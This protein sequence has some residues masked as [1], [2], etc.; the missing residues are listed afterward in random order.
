MSETNANRAERGRRLVKRYRDAGVG[1]RA[2]YAI[3]DTPEEVR[4][5][6]SLYYGRA[7]RALGRFTLAATGAEM[8]DPET[9]TRGEAPVTLRVDSTLVVLCWETPDRWR[10]Y[11]VEPGSAPAV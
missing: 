6:V 5:A 3:D 2:A 1:L 8:P 10:V 7:E 4:D 9:F 11:T